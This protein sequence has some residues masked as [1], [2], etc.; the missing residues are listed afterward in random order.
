MELWTTVGI[1]ILFAVWMLTVGKITKRV[2][3]V[4]MLA[5]MVF[6]AVQYLQPQLGA[7]T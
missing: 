6:I 3:T 1:T 2:G 5:Y 7:L 4:M